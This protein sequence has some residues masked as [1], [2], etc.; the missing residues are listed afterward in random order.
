VRNQHDRNGTDDVMKGRELVIMDK[1]VDGISLTQ[2]D[3]EES[4]RNT[5]PDAG[6]TDAEIKA[7][8]PGKS[9]EDNL[10]EI[11]W[12]QLGE[13]FDDLLHIPSDKKLFSKLEIILLVVKK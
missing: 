5:C 2:K 9:P 11:D 1:R 12:I 8:G 7:D 10:D 3:Q 6:I 4:D 13:K